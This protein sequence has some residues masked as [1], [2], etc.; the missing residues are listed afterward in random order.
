V[1]ISLLIALASA[2]PAPLSLEDFQSGKLTWSARKPPLSKEHPEYTIQ[3]E[4]K[5]FFLRGEP[6]PKQDGNIVYM[7]KVIDLGKTPLL[8]WKWRPLVLPKK[9]DESKK[10]KN[11][12][13]L[14]VYVYF[15]SGLRRRILKY[16]WS[17]SHPKGDWIT[18]SG[19]SWFW[20]TKIHTLES[21]EPVGKW[22]E[23]TVDLQK[24]YQNAFEGS[25]PEKAHGI[26]VLTD[27]DQTVS[28]AKG[29][30]D[31]FIALPRP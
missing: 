9:G 2:A 13:A 27:G 3:K 31:D 16:V 15:Q 10:G 8:R 18:S 25:A 6:L 21:G 19:S 14:G 12:S 23:E 22:V 17:T 7:Q 11:D 4:E 29:D 28:E 1:F 26:G 30:Y 5:N 24:D 20:T